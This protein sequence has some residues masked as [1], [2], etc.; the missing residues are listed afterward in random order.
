MVQLFYEFSK[1][2]CFPG[3]VLPPGLTE[4]SKQF[5]IMGD[6][7]V[8]QGVAQLVKCFAGAGELAQD[9][10]RHLNRLTHDSLLA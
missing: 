10:S 4:L 1:R 2:A 9:L 8:F 7:V 3:Q 6:E 5:R